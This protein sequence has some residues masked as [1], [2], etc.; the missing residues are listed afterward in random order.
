MF[1]S[2]CGAKNADEAA[3]CSGCGKPLAGNERPS[4]SPIP[5][6]A[7]RAEG[8]KKG[9]KQGLWIGLGVGLAFILL[10]FLRFLAR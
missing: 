10:N 6:P 2:N 7:Q 9:A 4:S 5:T 1:C 8:A 3:F